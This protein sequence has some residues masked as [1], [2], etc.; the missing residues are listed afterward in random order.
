MNGDAYLRRLTTGAMQRASDQQKT[1]VSVNMVQSETRPLQRVQKYSFV[2]PHGLV[3]FAQTQDSANHRIEKLDDD[4]EQIAAEKK[5]LL[6]AQP[7]KRDALIAEK[8]AHK[9]AQKGKKKKKKSADADAEQPQAEEEDSIAKKRKKRA[10][11]A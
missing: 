11:S 8:E 7:K 6:K 4:L 5:G 10:S 9:M 2:A 1:R 3:R